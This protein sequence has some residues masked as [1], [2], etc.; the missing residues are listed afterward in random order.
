VQPATLWIN[1]IR[2]GRFLFWKRE[3]EKRKGGEKR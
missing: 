2:W 3:N 1:V